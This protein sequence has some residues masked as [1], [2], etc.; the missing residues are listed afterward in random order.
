MTF[1]KGVSGNPAGRDPGSRNKRTIAAEER[2]FASADKLVDDLVKRALAGEPAASG[3]GGDDPSP[4]ALRA[5][6][7]PRQ[8]GEVRVMPASRIRSRPACCRCRPWAERS[9][10]R[11]CP[12]PTAPPSGPR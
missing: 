11:T 10:R 6:T 7:S 9:S 3:V 12:A 4:A 2:L 8:R 1:Q 5:A